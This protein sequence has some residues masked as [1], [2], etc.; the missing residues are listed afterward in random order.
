[1]MRRTICFLLAM[2]MAVS[3][4]ACG[5]NTPTVPETPENNNGQ[6]PTDS[7]VPR[8]QTTPQIPPRPTKDPKAVYTPPTLPEENRNLP[9]DSNVIRVCDKW[10]VAANMDTDTYQDT[11]FRQMYIYVLSRE[12]M[13]MNSISLRADHDGGGMTFYV[14]EN[15]NLGEL[16]YS[17]YLGYA[18]VDWREFYQWKAAQRDPNA[19]ARDKARWKNMEELD[20]AI[21]ELRER[22][23]AS[24]YVYDLMFGFFDIQEEQTVRSLTVSWPGVEQ[25]VDIGEI[26]LHPKNIYQEY[27]LADQLGIQLEGLACSGSLSTPFG[28]ELACSSI[29]ISQVAQEVTFTEV[30]SLNEHYRV[31]DVKIRNTAPGINDEH[32]LTAD[33]PVTVYPDAQASIQIFFT[34]PHLS[35]LTC[36]GQGYFVIDCEIN[37]EP[38]RFLWEGGQQRWDLPRE[39][40]AIV[41]DNV[42]IQGYYDYCVYDPE[43][44]DVS[45][46]SRE[47]IDALGWT[48]QWEAMMAEN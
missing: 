37:G 2:L 48:K 36:M 44:L 26:R 45:Y 12:P 24:I 40:W 33:H 31:L 29:D 30:S 22:P 25:T 32:T 13:D 38:C 8:E 47:A 34:G 20:D 7:P 35:E 46:A 41:M 21:S 3:L 23:L 27:G 19:Y 4:V 15:I 1:M 10:I 14:H 17:T 43:N 5:G 18:G 16:D 9:E 28:P 42:D 11:M 6:S 39:L